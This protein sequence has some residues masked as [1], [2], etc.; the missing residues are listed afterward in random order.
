MACPYCGSG[1]WGYEMDGDGSP[2]LEI[3]HLKWVSILR[4]CEC[5]D[6]GRLFM[7]SE[8]YDNSGLSESIKM[9]EVEE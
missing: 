4:R 3:A 7:V 8:L 9:E 5:R 2:R 1:N 6:C